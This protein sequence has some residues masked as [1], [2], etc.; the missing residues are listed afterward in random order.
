MEGEKAHSFIITSHRTG[1]TAG[2]GSY[3]IAR[4]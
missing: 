2:T 1:R 3:I 4:E